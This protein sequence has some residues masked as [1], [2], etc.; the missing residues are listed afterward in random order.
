MRHVSGFSWKQIWRSSSTERLFLS[1]SHC[2]GGLIPL[3][4]TSRLGLRPA[5]P[6]THVHQRVEQNPSWG[7]RR[8]ERPTVLLGCERLLLHCPAKCGAPTPWSAISFC[9]ASAV[10]TAGW[11]RKPCRG[12]KTPG[13]VDRNLGC[14]SL[15]TPWRSD[16]SERFSFCGELS[17]GGEQQSDGRSRSG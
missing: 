13:R 4:I 2:F 15:L 6:P 9:G 16:P 3:D 12:P 14:E 5:S 7:G 8:S 17:L 10:S 1:A 11:R